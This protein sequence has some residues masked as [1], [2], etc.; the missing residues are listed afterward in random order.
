MNAD[1]SEPV[2]L[3]LP[4]GA[5]GGGRPSWISNEEVAWPAF[6][7]SATSIVATRIESRELRVL[8]TLPPWPVAASQFMALRVVLGGQQMLYGRDEGTTT[9]IWTMDLGS[10]RERRLTPESEAAVFPVISPDARWLAYERVDRGSMQLVVAPAAGGPA[11]QLTQG[12]GLTWP[13]SWWTDGSRV[14]VA[15][16]RGSQ[17]SLGWMARETGE[18]RVLL[19]ATRPNQWLRYPEVSPSADRIVYEQGETFGNIWLVARPSP[20]RPR[21][22]S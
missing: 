21:G 7:E 14:A 6:S 1:G 17:W 4:P 2:S 3:P 19:E 12:R 10:G 13:H 18:T 8:R 16:R 11:R 20:E 22:T 5:N 9:G 15:M